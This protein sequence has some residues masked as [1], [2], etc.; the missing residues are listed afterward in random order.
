MTSFR[1]GRSAGG[2]WRRNARS[3]EAAEASSAA[4]AI[5]STSPLGLVARMPPF[6]AKPAMKPTRTGSVVTF[7]KPFVRRQGAVPSAV[8]GLLPPPQPAAASAGTA[9]ATARSALRVIGATVAGAA[10]ESVRESRHGALVPPARRTIRGA[11]ARERRLAREPAPRSAPAAAVGVRAARV[12]RGARATPPDALPDPGAYGPGRHVDEP[13]RFPADGSR[14]RR[15]AVRGGGLPAGTRGARR[16]VDL[17]RRLAV[18]RLTGGRQLPHVSLRGGRPV[19]GRRVSDTRRRGAPRHH[20]QV[21]R[22]LRRHGD[23]DAAAGPVRRPRHARRRRSLRALLPAGFPRGGPRA[24]RLLRGL[25]RPLLGGLPLT[26]RV[27]EDDGLRAAQHL[28]DG[29]VLL[30]ERGRI[31]RPAVRAADGRAPSGGLGTVARLGP[32]ADGRPARGR[33]AR[34]ARDLH[35][36]RNARPVLPRSG[37]RGLPPRARADRNHRRLLR[38]L[39]RNA[40][41]DRVSL[42]ARAALPR[43]SAAIASLAGP[44]VDRVARSRQVAACEPAF[45]LGEHLAAVLARRRP[46]VALPVGRPA[47]RLDRQLVRAKRADRGGGQIEEQPAEEPED[48]AEEPE[49]AAEHLGCVVAVL[50]RRVRLRPTLGQPE[51][52]GVDLPLAPVRARRA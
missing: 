30:G 36:R 21:E 17:V 34:P 29:C 1:C 9:R 44:E 20:R 45:D 23:A 46:R 42:S 32:R 15:S 3:V 24:T 52:E 12:R 22:R 49:D 10:D 27:L 38:A 2:A 41:R 43:R 18:P 39:R 33:A 8:Y 11:R 28:G 48:A 25:L 7:V 40:Q 50:E 51:P 47:D 16:R 6:S 14:A 13:S 19:R 5:V 4:N 26:A 31:D 35:R 37:R